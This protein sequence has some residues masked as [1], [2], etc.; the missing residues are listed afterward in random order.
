MRRHILF[1]GLVVTAMSMLTAET[2]VADHC[3][4]NGG[5]S[6][7]GCS[8][9]LVGSY[10]GTTYAAPL[11]TNGYYYQPQPYYYQPQYYRPSTAYFGSYPSYGYSSYGYSG[12]S[13]PGISIQFGS[14]FGS[15]YGYR[16]YSYGFGRS[17][18]SGFGFGSSLLY[19]GGH[20]HH[21][22]H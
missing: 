8:T 21:H 7:G 12:Y 16:P 15:S 5:Y 19:R 13:R 18:G 6:I 11:Q 2:V 20:H 4:C 1:A 22:H 3:S 17:Y 10:G 14:G 9:P